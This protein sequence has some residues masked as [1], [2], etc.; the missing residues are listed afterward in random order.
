MGKIPKDYKYA[1]ERKIMQSGNSLVV[2]LP[3]HTLK[4]AGVKLGKT[5]Y[6]YSDGKTRIIIELK[7][8]L[9]L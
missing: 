9:D 2:G 4:N 1:G 5:V 7:P 6:V 8:E 3:A